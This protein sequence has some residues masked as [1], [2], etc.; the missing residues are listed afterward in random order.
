MLTGARRVSHALTLAT[1]LWWAW[2]AGWFAGPDPAGLLLYADELSALSAERG[3]PHWNALALV[4]RGW[5]L[6]AS[7]DAGQ[8]IQ[9]LTAGLTDFGATGTSQFMPGILTI[10]ADAHRMSGQPRVGLARL[11]EAE[12]LAEATQERLMEPETL[13][14]KGDLLILSNNRVAAETSFRRAIALARRQEAKLWELRAA[15]SVARLWRGQGKRSEAR[16]LLG[17]IYSWFTEGFD[18]PVLK[19]AKALLEQLEA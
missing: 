8:S 2:L 4:A 12:R 9:M 13:R 1:A 5:C 14:M 19:G 3:F 10:L 15:T 16:D 11:A 18:T 7:G 17:P 6:A